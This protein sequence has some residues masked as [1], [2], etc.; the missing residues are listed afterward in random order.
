MKT[1]KE[2][3]KILGNQ[4]KFREFHGIKSG[5]PEMLICLKVGIF[6]HNTLQEEYS[7]LTGLP[8][9]L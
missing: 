2:Q 8:I 7:L 4:G 3:G 9:V 5:K 6:Q 1:K